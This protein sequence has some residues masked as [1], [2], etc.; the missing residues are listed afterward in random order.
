LFTYG[1]A[2]PLSAREEDGSPVI[3]C[4]AALVLSRHRGSRDLP[5]ISHMPGL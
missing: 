1:F 5:I 2:G 4:K 3:S